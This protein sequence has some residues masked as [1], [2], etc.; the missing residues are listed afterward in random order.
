MSLISHALFW[1][2]WRKNGP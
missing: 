2:M 1:N